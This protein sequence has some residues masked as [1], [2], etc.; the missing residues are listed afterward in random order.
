M[1]NGVASCGLRVAGYG[2][3]PACA[4]MTTRGD[5]PRAYAWGSERPRTYVWGSDSKQNPQRN[6]E[7]KQF[8]L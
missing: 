3:I 7:A 8:I 6:W 1:V 2:W 4:G 5:R